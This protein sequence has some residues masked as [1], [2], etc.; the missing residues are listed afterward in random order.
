MS[1][2]EVYLSQLVYDDYDVKE[3][4]KSRFYEAV[5]KMALDR[6]PYRPHH[7][8]TGIAE[9]MATLDG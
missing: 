6:F 7:V 5:Y 4:D 2:A 9:L 1:E 3:T 8:F